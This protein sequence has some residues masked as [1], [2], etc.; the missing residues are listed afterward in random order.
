M[1]LIPFETLEIEK[2]NSYIETLT[3]LEKYQV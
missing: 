3:T 1:T 2:I